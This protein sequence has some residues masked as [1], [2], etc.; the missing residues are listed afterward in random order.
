MNNDPPV[1]IIVL[2]FNGRSYLQGC[3]DSVKAQDYP[4]FEIVLVDNASTDGSVDFIRERYPEVRLV[5][6]KTNLGFAGGN[7]TGVDVAA[8]DLIVLVNN[9][10]VVEPGWLRGLVQGVLEPDVAIASSLVRTVGIPELFYER[11]GTVSLLGQNV[12]LAFEDPRDLFSC[13]G[14]SLIFRKSEFGR[15]FD[16][17]YFAYAEDVY[18]SLR[19]RFAG[20]RVRHVPDSRLLH[21]GG[22]TSSRERASLVAFLQER[23]R[24]LN[25]LIFFGPWTRI[26]LS[27]YFAANVI[28]KTL[29]GLLK[30]PRSVPGYWSAYG[31]LLT[32][33]RVIAR[34]R[35]ALLTA[36]TVPDRDVLRVMSCKLLDSESA[37]ARALNKLSEWY[38]RLVGLR[39]IEHEPRS[40]LLAQLRR[41]MAEPGPRVED[42]RP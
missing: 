40:P 8:H 30:T 14:C 12:M 33:P 34:K 3:L 16:P 1:S 4:S 41:R 6:G 7:N 18:L 2:N 23:N 17:D 24:I 39:T 20:R 38:C 22:G 42:P 35:K 32:H 36:K 9:D 28:G 19:A 21:F 15:P 31:W 37:P 27:P 10:V 11:N 13:T 5:C 25:D 29:I 26:R